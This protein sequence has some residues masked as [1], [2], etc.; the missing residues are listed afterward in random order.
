MKNKRETEIG[1]NARNYLEENKNRGLGKGLT[2]GSWINNQK[3]FNRWSWRYEGVM[4]HQ[5]Y[6]N[7][8]VA[9][10]FAS[11]KGGTAYYP[12]AMLEG[13]NKKKYRTILAL[14][15][16]DPNIAIRPLVEKLLKESG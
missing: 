12:V 1:K 16:L 14:A 5:L 11:C 3:G 13:D 4:A 15:K 2:I 9:F 7:Q 6:E 8:D 10:C